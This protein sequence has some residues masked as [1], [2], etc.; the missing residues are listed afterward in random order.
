MKRVKNA[1]FFFFLVYFSQ[2]TWNC[3]GLFGS[4][5][6]KLIKN[7]SSINF[8]IDSSIT[9][10]PELE[11][12]ISSYRLE[13]ENVMSN[14]IGF[15]SMNL[16][17]GRPEGTLNN[18]IADLML[19]RANIEYGKHVHVAITNISGLRREIP[20]GSITVGMI[21]EV[22]PFENELVVLEMKGSQILQLAQQ[23]GEK[24]G[25]CVSGIRIQYQGQKPVA[26]V[27]QAE[28]LKLDNTY[29]VTTTDYLSTPGRR[30][31]GALG[32]GSREFLGVLIRDAILEEIRD[33]NSKGESITAKMDGRIVFNSK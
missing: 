22:Y 7:F 10:D 18:F 29:F 17:K 8:P 16:N 23:I 32:Q 30:S 27:I 1:L 6:P 28:E 31:L 3:A 2:I 15:A 19:K 33:L 11:Q 25:E 12:L 5:G 13:M 4:K 24:G 26:I 9:D 21:Y 14:V 20:A